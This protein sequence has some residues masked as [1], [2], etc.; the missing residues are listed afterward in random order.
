MGAPAACLLLPAVYRAGP[1]PP[2]QQEKDTAAETNS[3]VGD[4][5]DAVTTED[6]DR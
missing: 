4:F 1:P 2:T 3:K 5:I 6:Q